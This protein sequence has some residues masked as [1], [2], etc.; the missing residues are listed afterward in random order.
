MRW[1]FRQV[2]NLSQTRPCDKAIRKVEGPPPA[3]SA[4]VS[5]DSL[6]TW[7]VIESYGPDRMSDAIV[8]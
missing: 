3:D 6:G 5:R 4:G 1:S 7:R 2:G 8:L